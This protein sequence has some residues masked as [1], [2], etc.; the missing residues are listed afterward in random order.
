M[1]CYAFELLIGELDALTKIAGTV[2][3]YIYIDIYSVGVGLNP[4]LQRNRCSEDSN[5]KFKIAGR[6]LSYHISVYAGR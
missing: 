4:R 6:L 2:G 3:R 5:L 1:I